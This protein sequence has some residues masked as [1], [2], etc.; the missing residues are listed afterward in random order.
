MIW[1]RGL[2]S[3]R[4]GPAHSVNFDCF[5]VWSFLMTRLW[6]QMEGISGVTAPLAI[7]DGPRMM[8]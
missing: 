8:P 2:T 1:L 4:D 5:I 3:L 7:A 6:L